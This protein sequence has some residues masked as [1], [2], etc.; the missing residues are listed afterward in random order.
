[1]TV[2]LSEEMTAL[3]REVSMKEN[4]SQEAVIVRAFALLKLSEDAKLKGQSLGVIEQIGFP[5]EYQVV[6]KIIGL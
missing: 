5:E 6:S 3:I 2:T 1:M 4:I